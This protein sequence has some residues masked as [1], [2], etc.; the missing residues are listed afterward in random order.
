MNAP[1]VTYSDLAGR[2]VFISGGA[3][4]IG[5]DLVIAF[6]E[7]S[8]NVVFIDINA[9]AGEA[10]R[11]ELAAKGPAI[12]FIRCDV[13]DDAAL[14]AAIDEAESQ[15][16]IE[17]LVNNA[18]N[19]ARMDI[20]DV[21]ADTWRRIVD[22]NLRH[23]FV[24]AQR[25]SGYMKQRNRGSIINFGS[26]APEAMVENLA[27]YSTCKSAVRGFTRSLA[28]DL[29]RFGIRANSILPGAILT[30]RQRELWFRDQAS[31][32][33][34]LATQCLKRELCGRDVAEMALFLASDVSA[35]CSAQGFIVDGGTI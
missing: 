32:D 4:G 10:L 34:V 6:H 20:A 11:D 28:R 24:A 27:I 15:G 13:T 25:V 5:R 21:D 16:P 9:E 17:V 12:T 1:L 19:D 3:T 2:T 18:A 23:Q 35:A 8:A 30:E 26:I 29:G 33:A 14:V 31:I 22:V 7:Q